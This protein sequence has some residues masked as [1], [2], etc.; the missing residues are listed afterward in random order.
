MREEQE[1]VRKLERG[2]LGNEEEEQGSD[3][4]SSCFDSLPVTQ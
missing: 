2:E 4:G 1:K 3:D